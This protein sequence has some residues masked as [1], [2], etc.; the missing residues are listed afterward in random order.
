MWNTSDSS[1]KDRDR[2]SK[3][4]LSSFP[5]AQLMS[6]NIIPHHF[7]ICRLSL[8]LIQRLT[9]EI[10]AFSSVSLPN[11]DK[12]SWKP[13]ISNNCVDCAGA[14]VTGCFSPAAQ[15]PQLHWLW[16]NQNTEK[17]EC[18]WNISGEMN[19]TWKASKGSY[20]PVCQQTSWGGSI[21]LFQSMVCS[22]EV[23]FKWPVSSLWGN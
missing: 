12:K 19:P 2:G 14:P 7:P 20:V 8:N 5:M 6:Q 15:L 11:D 22:D 16:W 10:C 3:E 21:G 4:F 23:S 1:G 13:D 17:G 18:L 9:T